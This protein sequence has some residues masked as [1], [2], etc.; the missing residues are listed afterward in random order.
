MGSILGAKQSLP[1]VKKR[2]VMM[3]AGAKRLFVSISADEDLE[4]G[5]DFDVVDDA[6]LPRH[7]LIERLHS[8][9]ILLPP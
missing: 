9:R 8:P 1:K 7:P 6:R 3:E 2:T 4:L 5:F